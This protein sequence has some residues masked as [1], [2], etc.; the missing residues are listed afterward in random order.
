MLKSSDRRCG[1]P[2]WGSPFLLP[3]IA[4]VLKNFNAPFYA[5]CAPINDK[6]N[7]GTIARPNLS[8][9]T[10]TAQQEA[11]VVTAT[12]PTQAPRRSR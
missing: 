6:T 4:I 8:I 9:A 11:A 3:R 10:C 7:T 2:S 12:M 1:I 5:Q